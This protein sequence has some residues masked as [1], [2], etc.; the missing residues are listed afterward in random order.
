M[1]AFGMAGLCSVWYQIIQSF[2]KVMLQYGLEIPRRLQVIPYETITSAMVRYVS[3]WQR[4]NFLFRR[5]FLDGLSWVVLDK[6]QDE[7]T[8]PEPGVVPGPFDDDD[9]SEGSGDWIDRNVQPKF[10]RRLAVSGY[11]EGRSC[12]A[13]R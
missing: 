3:A 13:Q 4:D 7:L 10:C 2:A 8:L 1:A 6:L 12:P 9:A 11:I 5:H